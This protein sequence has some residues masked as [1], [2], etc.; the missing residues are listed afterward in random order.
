M[1]DAKTDKQLRL[2]VGLVASGGF[3]CLLWAG[4]SVTAVSPGKL[5]YLATLTVI[6]AAANGPLI[7][8]RIRSESR[9]FSSTSGAILIAAATVP[10]PW[11]IL[12]TAVG[13]LASKNL[14]PRQAE[15]HIQRREGHDGRHG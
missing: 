9:S 11:V 6:I 14:S 8:L 1:N 3:L 12:C 2:Y 10:L 7:V 5:L 4:I 15:D 13:V